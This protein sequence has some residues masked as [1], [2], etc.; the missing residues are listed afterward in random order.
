MNPVSLE[1]LGAVGQQGVRHWLALCPGS[2]HRGFTP[3]SMAGSALRE[4]RE[5][6]PTEPSRVEEEEEEE[7]GVRRGKVPQAPWSALYHHGDSDKPSLAPL[8]Q[9]CPISEAQSFAIFPPLPMLPWCPQSK[10]APSCGGQ[11]RGVPIT[12]P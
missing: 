7:A 4:K 8:S 10:D 1:G 12:D 9:G 3:L 2:A 6:V 5:L 11:Q